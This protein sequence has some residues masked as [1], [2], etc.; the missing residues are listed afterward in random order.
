[1]YICIQVYLIACLFVFFYDICQDVLDFVD[2][3]PD[4]KFVLGINVTVY[5]SIL[6]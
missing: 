6:I 4:D 1:M 5:F 3:G 2:A